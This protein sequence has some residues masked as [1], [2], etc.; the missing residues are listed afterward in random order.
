MVVEPLR[1]KEDLVRVARRK[2]LHLVLDR[3]AITRPPALDRARK[4]RRTVEIGADDLVRLF[5]RACDRAAQLHRSNAVIECRYGPWL[6]VARLLLQSYPV[7]RASIEPRRRSRLQPPLAQADL[8]N[9]RGQ[10]H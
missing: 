5:G 7:D 2:A 9:L 1:L 8:A 10:P 3:R 6:R 4:Q